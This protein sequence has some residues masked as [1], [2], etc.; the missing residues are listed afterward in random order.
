MNLSKLEVIAL[1]AAKT[2][3]LGVFVLALLVLFLF[4]SLGASSMPFGT[5]TPLGAVRSSEP[6][7]GR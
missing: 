3:L 2:L 5:S 4:F 7:E 1:P 6:R